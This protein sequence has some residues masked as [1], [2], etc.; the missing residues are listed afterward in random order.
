MRYM[1][2]YSNTDPMELERVLIRSATRGDCV[3]IYPQTEGEY[4]DLIAAFPLGSTGFSQQGRNYFAARS[5]E[6]WSVRIVRPGTDG[7]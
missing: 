6:G 2:S 5:D 3:W 7:R 1:T 4:R